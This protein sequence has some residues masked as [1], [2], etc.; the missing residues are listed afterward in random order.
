VPLIIPHSKTNS[1]KTDSRFS[2]PYGS[3]STKNINQLIISRTKKLAPRW[4]TTI[5]R[6]D[7]HQPLKKTKHKKKQKHK[8]TQ[9]LTNMTQITTLL[10][11]NSHKMTAF[12]L[13]LILTVT[14]SITFAADNHNNDAIRLVNAS[15]KQH[16]KTAQI[17]NTEVSGK[18]T[19]V[20]FK[21]N[22]NI[23]TAFYADNGNLLAVVHNMLSTQL[24]ADLQTD[25]KNNYGDYWITELFELKGEDHINHQSVNC[26][27]ISLENANGKVILRSVDDS[28]WEVYDEKAKQ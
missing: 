13:A 10:N 17:L 5:Y 1:S 22:D 27:Y 14:T 26:Y 21:L 3:W 25:L 11:R 4:H 9:K 2:K 16:F 15:F 20:T 28:N 8:K 12:F 6:P 18:Y 7:K 23:M 24:P 19:K